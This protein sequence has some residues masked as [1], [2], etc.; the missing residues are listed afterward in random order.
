MGTIGASSYT[1]PQEISGNSAPRCNNC[2]SR[3]CKNCPMFG[4]GKNPYFE[5]REAERLEKL[6]KK[7]LKQQMEDS[8]RSADL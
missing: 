2:P 6:A 5:K 7:R 3:G 1:S 8:S 4:I